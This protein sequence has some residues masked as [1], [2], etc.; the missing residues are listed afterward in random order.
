MPVPALVGPSLP[1]RLVAGLLAL[2]MMLALAWLLRGVRAQVMEPKA[3]QVVVLMLQPVRSMPLQGGPAIIRQRKSAPVQL[4]EQE[5]RPGVALGV[6]AHPAPRAESP[7]VS[8]ATSLPDAAASAPARPLDLGASTLRSAMSR[9]R[10]AVQQLADASGQDLHSPRV[11][12]SERLRASMADAGVPGCL[13]ADALKHDPPKIGPI[14]VQ[15]I[16]VAPFMLQAALSGK[17][18]T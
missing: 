13:K 1:V 14:G 8:A 17:C 7:E 5:S 3:R 6:P 15:G 4:A 16:L 2:L 10:G 18:K 11:S 9:S 12:E